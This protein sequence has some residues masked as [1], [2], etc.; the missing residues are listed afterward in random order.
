[1]FATSQLA[2]KARKRPAARDAGATIA[3]FGPHTMRI[4]TAAAAA[5]AIVLHT[6][7]A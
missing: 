7:R 2:T 3:S 4:E 1:M 6:L 5:C